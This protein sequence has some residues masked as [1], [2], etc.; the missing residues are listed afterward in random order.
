MTNFDL[1]IFSQYYEKNYIQSNVL[2]KFNE[3]R[4]ENLNKIINDCNVSR[5]TAKDLF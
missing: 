3:K 4:E 5:D 1:N 2:N